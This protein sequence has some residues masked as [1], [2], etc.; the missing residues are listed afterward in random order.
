MPSW[1][2]RKWFLGEAKSFAQLGRTSK[3][4]YKIVTNFIIFPRYRHLLLIGVFDRRLVPQALENHLQQLSIYCLQM[5][6]DT[7]VLTNT[8]MLAIT[9]KGGEAKRLSA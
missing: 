9:L 6:E 8:D 3:P 5:S 1:C 4:W 2:A 7:V